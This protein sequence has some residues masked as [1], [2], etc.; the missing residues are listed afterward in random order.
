VTNKNKNGIFSEDWKILQG[1][2][3]SIPSVV[4]YNQFSA[5]DTEIDAIQVNSDMVA[6]NVRMSVVG[7][8]ATNIN[9]SV[10][11]EFTSY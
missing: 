4:K 5:K 3:A 6:D 11:V 2:A 7:I 10:I 9:W 8:A 1:A